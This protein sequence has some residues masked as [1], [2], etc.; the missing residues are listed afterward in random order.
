MAGKVDP[1]TKSLA[2]GDI[3]SLLL[4]AAGN[5]RVSLRPTDVGALGSYL[6]T[7]ASGTIAATMAGSKDL[8]AF[9]N[10][11]ASPVIVRRVVVSVQTVGA[12]TAGVGRLGL[13]VARAFSASY[14]AN[15]VG[16][17]L[18]GNN[19]KK[20]T[21]FGT[22]GVTQIYTLDTNVNGI[23]GAT[24]TLDSQ[25]AGL[26]TFPIPATAN[27]AVLT[28]YVIYDGTAP[29]TWPVVLATNEGLVLQNL[30]AWVGA[31]STWVVTVTVDWDEVPV[32]P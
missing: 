6:I 27:F 17:T 32:A 29:G 16:A 10:G 5:L 25:A 30:I 26:A 9:R 20:K 2:T 15:G 13:F 11:G 28:N 22:T 21:A 14:S 19:A 4:D 12:P 23:T 31:S 24:R 1:N 8:W 3:K 18:T 7:T